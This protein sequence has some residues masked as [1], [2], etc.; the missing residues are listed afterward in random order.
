MSSR[1]FKTMIAHVRKSDHKEQTV[2]EHCRQTAEICGKHSE[3][4]GMKQTGSINGLLHDGGKA[5]KDF[6]GYV[7]GKTNFSRG[8]IDHAFAGAKYIL[9]LASKTSSREEYFVSRLMARVIVSHHGLHDWIDKDHADYLAKRT[10]KEDRYDEIRENLHGMISDEKL[11][12]LLCEAGQ[13]YAT[14]NKKLKTLAKSLPD[15]VQ[16]KG[17]AFYRG[18]LE[19]FMLSCLID[20]DRTDT[21]DFMDNTE[22]E[23]TY[24][25]PAVWKSM[26][27]RMEAKC[28]AFA[29]KKDPI[30]LRRSDISNRCAKFAKNKVGACRLIVPTGGGKTYSSIRFAIETC[31]EHGKTKILYVAP[32]MSIL[33]QNSDVLKEIAG[34]E[35]FTEHHSN[36][37]AE[38]EDEDE[39]R[40]YELRTEKW[41]APVIATTMVQFLNAL[42]SGKM[43][44]V[45]RMHRLA[46]AVIILDEVQSM[47]LKCLHLFNLAVNFLVHICGITVVLCTAT[48][49]P[50]TNAVFPLLLD[51]KSSMTGDTREDFEA[52]Q[53]TRVI[54][55]KKSWNYGYSLEEAADFCEEK[56]RTLGNTLLIVN[57][58]RAA[59]N[60]FRKLQQKCPD[61]LLFHLSTNMCQRH[62]KDRID[63]MKDALVKQDRLVICVTTQLIEAGVDISFRCVVRSLA[64]L[65]NIAQ[66][67]G[68]CNRNG[69][70]P[71]P[72]EVYVVNMQKFEYTAMLQGLDQSRNATRT[73][74]Y[75]QENLLSE[76][77][78]AQY[79]STL[80]KSYR[81]DDFSYPLTKIQIG[82]DDTL[83]NLLSLNTHSYNRSG[84]PKEIQYSCQAFST[85]GE[86]FE[87]IDNK[88]Q[89]IVVPYNDEAKELIAKLDMCD[90]PSGD[91]L[92]KAQKYTVGLYKTDAL[93]ERNAIRKLKS[94]VL[95]LEERFYDEDCGVT[96]EGK[97][98]ELLC[99]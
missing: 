4:I 55:D 41:D 46:N 6:D 25:L 43:G 48:Q 39:L 56:A 29:Q 70:Y 71:H 30:S 8:E 53:R 42:F 84:K 63:Q 79:Y 61:A 85:A 52:F 67:A 88:T 33:D 99:T 98:Q 75:G 17:Y 93:E 95:A 92:R 72:C 44:C 64:G 1:K 24:D 16:G 34:A 96:T 73:M 15:K 66:A 60:M 80:Y 62:R 12:A 35:N 89:D 81:E 91:L 23:K 36:I 11:A 40:E 50:V 32:F 7:R 69:E 77:A 83:L 13:E 76:T 82:R 3:F 97:A 10:S 59:Y 51:E 65:D 74:T 86:L 28:E 19:R 18:M 57:T 37:L 5:T 22:T 87:V 49:P 94:G 68:R 78:I 9:D 20:A 26:H 45:R 58:K 21:A 54:V 38:L 27:E 14:I 31:L 47:P 2:E 90:I